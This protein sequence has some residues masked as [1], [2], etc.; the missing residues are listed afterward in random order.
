[1]KPST[2][3]TG[4]LTQTTTNKPFPSNECALLC[5]SALPLIWEDEM[6]DKYDEYPVLCVVLQGCLVCTL[7]GTL[8]GS[9][10]SAGSYCVG[11]YE[12]LGHF[13]SRR[14]IWWHPTKA[15]HPWG[16]GIS[17]GW[18]SRPWLGTHEGRWCS[19]HSATQSRH[20]S[21]WRVVHH[22]WGGTNGQDA[23]KE[24]VLHHRKLVQHLRMITLCCC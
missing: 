6:H 18:Y 13:A 10:G 17:E 19:W 3:L 7:L 1:M 8:W 11:V 21:A 24:D 14:Q 4:I 12:A 9:R 20:V 22:L 5:S 16:H 23:A 2:T 15:R